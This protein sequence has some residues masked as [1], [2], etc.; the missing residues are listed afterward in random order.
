MKKLLI[1]WIRPIANRIIILDENMTILHNEIDSYES[2]FMVAK[3]NLV[4]YANQAIHM[5]RVKVSQE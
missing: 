1:S 3:K 2:S 5:Q 4:N